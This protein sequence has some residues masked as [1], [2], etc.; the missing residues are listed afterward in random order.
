MNGNRKSMKH[1]KKFVR[2]KGRNFV[3]ENRKR[4]LVKLVKHK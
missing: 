4:K 1:T 2:E 3:P